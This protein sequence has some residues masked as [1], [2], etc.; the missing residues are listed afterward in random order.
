M[1]E[2]QTEERREEEHDPEREARRR[3]ALAQM[4]RYGDPVLRMRAREVESFDDDLRRLAERMTALMDEAIGLGLAANQVGVLQRIFVMRTDAEEEPFAV[5]NPVIV[6]RADEVEE[7]DEGCLS[8]PSVH[9]PVE[10]SLSVRLEARDLDG[11]EL[12]LELEGL[13]AR[14]AQHELDHLD[15]VLMLDRTS[16]EARREALAALRPRPA[17]GRE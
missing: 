6:S 5:I 11:G 13:G 16:K 1:S 7:S 4:R 3:F 15:G 2:T 14:V 8:L 10:R 12:V 17:L 9:V